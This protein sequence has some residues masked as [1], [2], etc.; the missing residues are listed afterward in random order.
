MS[1]KIERLAKYLW[2]N[3]V[4]KIDPINRFLYSLQWEDV[5]PSAK[6]EICLFIWK[7]RSWNKKDTIK[8]KVDNTHRLRNKD[9]QCINYR[10]D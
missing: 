1:T 8:C 2:E 6:F 5:S 7:I 4:K 10:R 9:R 3:N